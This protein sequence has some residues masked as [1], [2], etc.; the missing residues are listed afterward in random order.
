MLFTV[1]SFGPFEI[2]ISKFLKFSFTKIA[3]VKIIVL[4][5]PVQSESE[6]TLQGKVEAFNEMLEEVVR[7]TR[8]C[9]KQ[10]EGSGRRLKSFG[11]LFESVSGF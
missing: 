2:S 7:F 11:Q 3:N 4:E 6:A 1:G 8:S 9:P 10:L 5:T